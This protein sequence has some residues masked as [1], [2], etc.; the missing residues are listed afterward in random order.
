MFKK[1]SKKTVGAECQGNNKVVGSEC[2]NSKKLNIL[3]RSNMAQK[4]KSPQI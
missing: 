4:N 1:H 2:S 3:S